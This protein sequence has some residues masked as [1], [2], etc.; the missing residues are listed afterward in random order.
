M[1]FVVLA[2]ICV[3]FMAACGGSGRVLTLRSTEAAVHEAGFSS[4]RVLD[5]SV[6]IGRLRSEGLDTQGLRAG[7]PDYVIPRRVPVVY[8]LRFTSVERARRV[9][10]KAYVGRVCNVVVYNAAPTITVARKGA[11]RIVAALTKRCK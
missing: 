1:R 7:T 11:E 9:R 6:A 3:A 8:V 2:S 4:L 5:A 10:N